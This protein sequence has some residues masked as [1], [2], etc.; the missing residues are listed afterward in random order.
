MKKYIAIPKPKKYIGT[1]TPNIIIKPK[2]KKRL[3]S[4]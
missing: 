1:Y 3:A 4:N 2:E